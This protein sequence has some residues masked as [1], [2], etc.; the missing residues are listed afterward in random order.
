MCITRRH[1]LVGTSVGDSK[2]H[3]FVSVVCS[4]ASN[5]ATKSVSP[6]LKG[7]S[8]R[9]VQ[10]PT[11][12]CATGY[13]L[14][15]GARV[16]STCVR[17]LAL[18]GANGSWTNSD[19][20]RTKG[21][22]AL[23]RFFARIATPANKGKVIKAL[24]GAARRGVAMGA[25]ALLGPEAA[26]LSD[27]LAGLVLGGDGRYYI[28]NSVARD[29]MARGL[30]PTA[31]VNRK[32][33][34]GKGAVS[35]TPTP[36]MPTKSGARL[37]ASTSRTRIDQTSVFT[38]QEFFGTVYQGASAG[39]TT[40]QCAPVHASMPWAASMAPGFQRYRFRQLVVMLHHDVNVTQTWSGGL[41]GGAVNY[42]VEGD[43]FA[44]K[45]Q[46]EKDPSALRPF[47]EH[48]S[49]PVECS[50]ARR[51]REWLAV[52]DYDTSMSIENTLAKVHLYTV[53][54]TGLTVGEPIGRL[55]VRYTIEFDT[56]TYNMQ[57]YGSVTYH[58][59]SASGT[60]PFGDP[61]LGNTLGFGVLRGTT[62]GTDQIVRL[63][64]VSQG[65]VLEVVITWAGTSQTLNYASG[66]LVVTGLSAYL[67]YSMGN[68]WYVG[69]PATAVAST[70]LT[71]RFLVQVTQTSPTFALPTSW[72]LPTASEVNMSI[73]LLCSGVASAKFKSQSIVAGPQPNFFSTVP[74]PM[75]WAQDVLDE[76]VRKVTCCRSVLDAMS[77][78]GPV[79]ID[80]NPPY[81]P[82]PI[83]CPPDVIY[84]Q[85][86]DED[87]DEVLESIPVE[88]LNAILLRRA[89]K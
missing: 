63:S 27:Q 22:A 75:R 36:L 29:L 4:P 26:M 41:W 76:D 65:D 32:K 62:V 71:V 81:N 58:A 20:V 28:S 46:V 21:D 15:L 53:P 57:R 8:D 2:T 25:G 85:L 24:K 9:P 83:P 69:V 52:P 51:S 54:A 33:K 82:E 17:D 16:C 31:P 23:R 47:T 1:F 5:N 55:Y 34:R 64:S 6:S 89:Q 66:G 19:D 74:R 44:C 35:V 61:T 84:P 60:D 88:K 14:M 11:C 40:V 78:R 59:S 87:V 42:D 72:T 79:G 3:D 50:P 39:W 12:M 77:A 37:A 80:V 10:P 38:N 45:N 18:N 56:P 48:V 13:P 70:A 67:G 73:N 86:V 7:T 49:I 68:L 30:I 43:D